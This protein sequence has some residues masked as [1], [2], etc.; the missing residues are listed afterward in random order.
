VHESVVPAP[1]RVFCVYEHKY[2]RRSVADAVVLGRFPIQGVT[3]DL[4]STPDWL[5]A[6]LPADKEWRLEWTKF[7]YGL[8]LAAAAEENGSTAYLRAWQRLVVS[9]IAQVPA[10]ADPSDVIGRRVQNWI[11]AWSRFAERFDLESDAPGFTT[12]ISTSLR[13]QVSHLEHHLTR[14]RNHRTLELYALFI[15]A[16]ALPA[17]DPGGRLLDFAV[18]AL[19]G[20]LHED[21]LPDGVQRERSTHYHHVVLRS[22]LGFRENARRFGLA[23][24]PGFDDRLERACEFALHCHRP[25]GHIPALSDSDSGSYLDLLALAGDLLG[26]PDF[27][28]VATRGRAGTAPATRHATFPLGGYFVQRSGWGSPRCSIADERYLIFD[29]GPLGD[30][31]HGH[32]DALNVELAAGGGPLVVDPG[33]YTYCDE[34]PHWRHWFKGTPA[35][36]TVTVDRLD[37]TPYR[38]GR[39]KGAVAEARLLQRGTSAGLDVLW[40]E[41]R[42]PAY[43]AIHR[44]RV[45]FVGDEYWLIEDELAANE[46]HRYELRFHLAPEAADGLVLRQL[47]GSIAAIGSRVAIIVAGGSLAATETGWISGE[48]GI[49]REAPVAVFTAESVARATFI[50]LVAPRAAGEREVPA[51]TVRRTGQLT[52]ATIH[53]GRGTPHDEVV[54]TSDG[55]EG[56]LPGCG[57][58]GL[59]AFSRRSATGALLSAVRMSRAD[60]TLHGRAAPDNPI[61]KEVCRS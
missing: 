20:N 11:Y 17:L 46:P 42:S 6:A 58:A 27:T 57:G 54:W 22:F 53:R 33:R 13:D 41:A 24:P 35:H 25:D 4:G 44:R 52:V 16:L 28:Y 37:Q 23:V 7:Y 45:V 39:P 50:T 18:D 47:S 30:G 43:P 34:A 59:A 51:L 32:Y 21:V 48:Y 29:C 14:E 49:K 38:R 26:R 2:Q 31:G 56:R 61:E 3:P 12:T 9:W 5:G 40:G 1:R 8:D 19:H 15:A 60:L 36:N 10:G 55:R